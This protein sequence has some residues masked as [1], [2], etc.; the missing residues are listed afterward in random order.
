MINVFRFSD[1]WIRRTGMLPYF[2]VAAACLCLW[3]WGIPRV[4]AVWCS[5]STT[6]EGRR[7][8]RALP[9]LLG[10]ALEAFVG[11]EL[12]MSSVFMIPP[13]VCMM[14]LTSPFTCVFTPTSLLCQLSSYAASCLIQT[15]ITLT[16]QNCWTAPHETHFWF[17]KGI[18]LPVL[19]C[20]K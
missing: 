14:S 10:P 5:A 9:V 11:G 16:S 6:D 18:W 3:I 8:C 13:G 20:G 4:F 2:D 19:V 7:R 1:R 17:C 15:D 12:G